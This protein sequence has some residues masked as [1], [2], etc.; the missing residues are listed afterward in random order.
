M[1]ISGNPTG[2][3]EHT[4]LSC[5]MCASLLGLL[6]LGALP[7]EEARRVKFHVSL[8]EQCRAELRRY[9]P[10]VEVLLYQVPLVRAPDRVR[11]RVAAIPETAGPAQRRRPVAPRWLWAWA[12]AATLALMIVGGWHVAL[13]GQQRALRAQ[14]SAQQDLVRLLL[15]PGARAVTLEPDGPAREVRAV[16]YYLDDRTGVLVVEGL[17][18]LAQDQAYQL[19]LIRPDGRRDNG[20]VFR[21]EAAGTLTLHRV[22][23]PSPWHR[24]AGVGVTVE[25]ATGSPGPTGPRVLH[26][27][28]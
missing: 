15:T 7:E 8:C 13:L 27:R 22:E 12:V 16:L 17:S 10:V 28:L 6:A 21:V 24:Y 4:T 14:M 2:Q 9:E 11:R 1:S 18:P 23:P 25:P 5:E 3:Q 20:G 26:G 19:W